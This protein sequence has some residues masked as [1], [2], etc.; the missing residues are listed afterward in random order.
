[1][2]AKR[3]FV[4]VVEEFFKQTKILYI[5]DCPFVHK[6]YS[7][8]P[9]LVKW[10]FI[11]AANLFVKAYPFVLE[12]R[13]RMIRETSFMDD[14][15]KLVKTP[16]II[17][18]DWVSTS[19]IREYINGTHFDPYFDEQEYFRLGKE[20]AMIHNSG[21]VMGDTKY[22]NFLK[23]DDKF[24][25]VDAEQAIRS[26]SHDYMFWDIFVFITTIIYKMMVD[27]P[28]RT[29]DL[30]RGRMNNF[31]NGYISAI[32]HDYYSILS[33]VDKFNYKTIMFMLLPYPLYIIFNDMIKQLIRK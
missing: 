7:K 11:K 30:I 23:I 17:V 26:N 5:D 24:Y 10:F 18:K 19:I 33:N 15:Y 27:N 13:S 14:E 20:L 12:P 22:T 4:E 2:S 31:L 8:E 28:F 16:H 32:E 9:G 21:Y 6:Q 29:K 25:V 1:M 3:G